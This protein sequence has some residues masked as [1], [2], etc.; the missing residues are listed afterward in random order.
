MRTKFDPKKMAQPNNR[1][2]MQGAVSN[3]GSSEEFLSNRLKEI[4]TPAVEAEINY[5]LKF[6][7]NKVLMELIS[8]NSYVCSKKDPFYNTFITVE[9]SGD[10]DGG[11]VED[12]LDN[13]L[14]SIINKVTKSKLDQLMYLDLDVLLNTN[15]LSLVLENYEENIFAIR[16]I[17]SFKSFEKEEATI[18]DFLQK[19]SQKNIIMVVGSKKEVQSTLSALDNP[20]NFNFDL[21]KEFSIDQISYHLKKLLVEK[22]FVFELEWTEALNIYLNQPAQSKKKKDYQYVASLVSQIEKKALTDKEQQL[23]KGKIIILKKYFLAEQVAFNPNTLESL[24]ELDKLI[25]MNEAKNRVKE[26]IAYLEF[27]QKMQLRTGKQFPL[28][29]H[30]M[31][32]G[33]PGTGKTTI[34]RIIAKVLFELGYIQKEEIV[35]VDKKDLV[36]QWVG[37]TSIKTNEVIQSAMGGVLFIDE[38]YS[39][40]DDK[41]GKDAIATLIK[42]MEDHKT[43][44][45]VIVAG[46]QDE[47]QKFVDTN[48]GMKSRLGQKIHFADYSADELVE[49]YKMKMSTYSMKTSESGIRTLRT[50]LS[51]ALT[52]ENF[53]N[54]RYVD[55]MIQDIFLTYAVQTQG[56]QMEAL[57]FEIKENHIPIK[58]LE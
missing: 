53:G 10:I 6:K 15:N 34:A 5:F 11:P 14:L 22:N 27:T 1:Q 35:E 16:D 30:M 41:Y 33:S 46:Y 38:A 26:L 29:L 24:K 58:Y 52:V 19:L 32:T 43:D 48:P 31:F 49:M 8:F 42:A 4:K 7:Y 51:K 56:V 20:T 25:G 54:G 36:S 55:N 13:V 18:L 47:M 2:V 21:T 39:V 28:N 57:E 45:V 23:N 40:A 12:T 3:T 9:N 37:H 17:K 44:L 50:A